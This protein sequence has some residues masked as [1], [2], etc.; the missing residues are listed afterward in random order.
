MSEVITMQ[1]SASAFEGARGC[2]GIL[3]RRGVSSGYVGLMQLRVRSSRGN[4]LVERGS[5]TGIWKRSD[6]C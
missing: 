4:E 3:L 2:R 6:A 1:D 5:D